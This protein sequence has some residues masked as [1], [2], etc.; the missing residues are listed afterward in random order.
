MN[1]IDI[2]D[3]AEIEDE[4]IRQLATIL[5]RGSLEEPTDSKLIN[6]ILNSTGE[7][8][9]QKAQ[10]LSH[11]I[12]EKNKRLQEMTDELQFMNYSL[13]QHNS[14]NTLKRMTLKELK[15]HCSSLRSIMSSYLDS[16]SCSQ[17]NK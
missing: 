15:Q 11:S 16:D 5:I 1:S 12:R 14:P 17:H 9:N 8:L 4:T 10:H 2:N 13:Q 7:Q 6:E 3:L